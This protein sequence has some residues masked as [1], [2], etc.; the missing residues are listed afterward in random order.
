MIKS[1]IY[2]FLYTSSHPVR[3]ALVWASDEEDIE[4]TER[5]KY[6]SQVTQ[7][8]YKRIVNPSSMLKND[9]SDSDWEDEGIAKVCT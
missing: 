5:H 9:D 2:I 7:R 3:R 6:W 1:T 8:T 4:I